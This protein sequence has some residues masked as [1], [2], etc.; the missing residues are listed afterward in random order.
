MP[1]GIFSIKKNNKMK[2]YLKISILLVVLT[3]VGIT[4]T[5]AQK[6]GYVNSQNLIALLPESETAAKDLETYQQKLGADFQVKVQKFRD[7]ITAFETAAQS[8][9]LTP[10]Q[11]QEQGAVLQKRQQELA[12]EERSLA[13]QVE[14]KR[15]ELLSPILDRLDKA[16]KEIGKEEGYSMIFDSAGMNVMLYLDESNDLTDKVKVKLGL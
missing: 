12:V 15:I 2:N 6:Y 4:N 10:L 8:G 13:Q 14:E 7:D 1:I 11:Q 3:L 5:F 9:T 16:V